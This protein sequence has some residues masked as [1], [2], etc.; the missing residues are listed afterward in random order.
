MKL[1]K[2]LKRKC[3][4]FLAA[5]DLF[6]NSLSP[7]I[8]L[9]YR[10]FSKKCR[11]ISRNKI[12]SNLDE[13][14]RFFL[15]EPKKIVNVIP[16]K[17]A[18]ELS[19]LISERVD[20][21]LGI[22]REINNPVFIGIE[23]PIS[24]LGDEIV[25]IFHHPEVNKALMTYFGGFY[26]IA[27]VDCYRTIPT[28]VRKQA[29]LW[30]S[31]NVPINLLKVQILLTDAKKDTGAINVLNHADTV[32]FRKAGYFGD[33]VSERLVDLAEF[34]K[35]KGIEF[36]PICCEANAGDILL[37][38]N[39]DL[40]CAVPP[41]NGFRDALTV[42]LFPCDIPWFQHYEKNGPY[43]VETQPGGYPLYP[44]N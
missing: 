3:Y 31:D 41:K 29:W 23:N 38:D 44:Q 15:K 34:A 12:S 35:N 19:Q 32:R 37:F 43:S 14:K 20:K 16:R 11:H 18:L 26:R 13:T 28:S 10:R 5:S 8:N 17:T 6:N 42:L 25:N 40:H 1:L 39:N 24:V 22:V 27:W 2:Q 4:R 9:R 36:N 30:H 33:I 7:K 21:K